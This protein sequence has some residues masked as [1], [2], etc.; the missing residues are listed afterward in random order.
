MQEPR[1][2]GMAIDLRN[3]K[4]I[5]LSLKNVV[6]VDTEELCIR[7]TLE[8]KTGQVARLHVDAPP[9]VKIGLP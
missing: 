9:T 8:A 3:G 5:V 6:G 4:T 7:I 2:K 1:L